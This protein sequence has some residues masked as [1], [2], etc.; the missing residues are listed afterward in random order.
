MRGRGARLVAVAVGWL[1]LVSAS[2]ADDGALYQWTDE[3]GVIRYTPR[4][5][6]VPRSARPNM[7]RLVPPEPA[8]HAET[9]GSPVTPGALP[10]VMGSKMPGELVGSDTAPTDPAELARRIDDLRQAIESDQAALRGLV[11]AGPDP[12]G[13]P[14]DPR[15]E[16]IANRLPV[17]QA[18]LA[19]LEAAQRERSPGVRQP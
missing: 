5:D 18:E 9:N 7:K 14:P 8:T 11:A 2:A 12:E 1:A 6:R 4:L 13:G 17:M 3:T 15:L 10:A 19:R 16:A